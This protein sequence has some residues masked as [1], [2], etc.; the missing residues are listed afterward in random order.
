[1]GTV[2]NIRHHARHAAS[3]RFADSI[4]TTLSPCGSGTRNVEGCSKALTIS[5]LAKKK[6]SILQLVFPDRPRKRVL[7]R[8]N[9]ATSKN[10][11]CIRMIFRHEPGCPEKTG[12]VF[13]RMITGNQ[14][15][16]DGVSGQPDF[17]ANALTRVRIGAKVFAIVASWNHRSFCTAIPKSFVL[18]C[19]HTAVV[20][21][22]GWITREWDAKTNEGCRPK[23]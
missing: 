18:L 12:M 7:F 6:Y 3:H 5:A 15:D 14:A 20:D 8:G 22:A 4:R 17:V 13:H 23:A 1:M 10:E 2:T 21:N 11:V 16:E 19:A 9:A